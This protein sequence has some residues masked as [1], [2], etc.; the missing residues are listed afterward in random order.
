MEQTIKNFYSKLVR[1]LPMD[2]PYFRSL[3]YTAD[4]LPGNLKDEVQSKPTRAER[5]EY[6]LDKRIKN[7][8]TNFAK[9]LEVLEKSTDSNMVDL[10]KQI[11]TEIDK[12]VSYIYVQSNSTTYVAM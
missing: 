10:A 11:R 4:L 12:S 8:V 9:L 5:A 1:T 7:N 3:L 6:F 2:D